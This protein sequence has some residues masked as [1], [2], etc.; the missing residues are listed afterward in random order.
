MVRKTFLDGVTH[1]EK[2]TLGLFLAPL[3]PCQIPPPIAPIE[4]APPK[5]FKM[6]YG[7]SPT[8]A[9]VK[10][11]ADFLP[12]G[13][14]VRGDVPGVSSVISS[15]HDV[16]LDIKGPGDVSGQKSVFEIDFFLLVRV[17]SIHSCGVACLGGY[18][19][20]SRGGFE[21]RWICYDKSNDDF[22]GLA[23]GNKV[24]REN[25]SKGAG[26]IK[27]KSGFIFYVLFF[28]FPLYVYTIP[29]TTVPSSTIPRS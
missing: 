26:G 15:R 9:P 14:R 25:G 12:W 29:H 13:F 22:L 16:L 3:I 19:L 10:L 28:L 4:N 23:G 17:S 24:E 5:S 21:G 8:L 27:K 20:V 6:T 2:H 7:L 11:F 1:S 18:A